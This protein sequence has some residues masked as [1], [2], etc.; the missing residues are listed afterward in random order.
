MCGETFHLFW[1]FSTNRLSTLI[2]NPIDLINPTISYHM[3][4]QTKTCPS[5]TRCFGSFYCV[6]TLKDVWVSKS[7]SIYVFL[8]FECFEHMDPFLWNIL[9]FTKK[10]KWIGEH[11]IR[12]NDF[13]NKKTTCPHVFFW[14]LKCI[15]W[16][17]K[18]SE[19]S[20]KFYS[21]NF[22]SMK[23]YFKT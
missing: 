19:F 21:C 12:K 4:H 7:K 3:G 11:L 23:I 22:E 17:L 2:Y 1:I 8:F 9:K 10:L 15:K 13:W 18:H 14:C 5:R 16:L 6:F 20:W